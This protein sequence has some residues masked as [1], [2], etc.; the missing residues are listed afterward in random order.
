MIDMVNIEAGCGGWI[1][2][3][4]VEL[5]MKGNLGAKNH[6]KNRVHLG[7]VVYE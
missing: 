5:V 7:L 2:K 3:L 6:L 1:W 4:V